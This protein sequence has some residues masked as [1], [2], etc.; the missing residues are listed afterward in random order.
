MLFDLLMFR[1]SSLMPDLYLVPML[2]KLYVSQ[3]L[4][5]NLGCG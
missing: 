3:I 2:P 1:G 4:S 5:F